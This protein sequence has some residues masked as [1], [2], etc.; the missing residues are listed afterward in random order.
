MY[1]GVAIERSA[2]PVLSLPNYMDSA[3]ISRG[4]E[5]QTL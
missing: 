1:I 4:D 5:N 2:R 3:I